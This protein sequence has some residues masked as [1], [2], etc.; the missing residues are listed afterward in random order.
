M[1]IKERK[2]QTIE[3]ALY[4]YLNYTERVEDIVTSLIDG[5]CTKHDIIYTFSK[6]KDKLKKLE[7]LIKKF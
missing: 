7:M 3:K 1:T 5:E 4:D 6:H 2:K